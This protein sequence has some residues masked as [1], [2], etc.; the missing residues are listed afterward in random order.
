MFE[1]I[2]LTLFGW[3]L[4]FCA[5]L[6]GLV[7][8]AFGTTLQ[9]GDADDD[10]EDEEVKAG[11]DSPKKLVSTPKDSFDIQRRLAVRNKIQKGSERPGEPVGRPRRR[12]CQ[13]RRQV[14][15]RAAGTV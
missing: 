1:T 3:N 4:N 10:E 9:N 8:F 6:V 5:L 2:D 7:F 13:R 14:R 11:G 12:K 15:R